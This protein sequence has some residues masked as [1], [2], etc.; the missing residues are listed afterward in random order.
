MH[1]SHC[2]VKPGCCGG[3]AV[4][5]C[6]ALDTWSHSST[7][8]AADS[9]H[10]AGP[11]VRGD[12]TI[13]TKEERYSI[14]FWG[15]VSTRAET[16]KSSHP[17]QRALIVSAAYV[18][19]SPTQLTEMEVHL[20]RVFISHTSV[21]ESSCQRLHLDYAVHQ[22][23]LSDLSCLNVCAARSDDVHKSNIP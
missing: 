20:Q 13:P 1:L 15:T 8:P 19:A 18:L 16:E 23:C 3:L 17:G 7:A 5:R 14:F 6:L 12:C 10:T 9:P 11:F 22:L 2:G 4:F 21:L